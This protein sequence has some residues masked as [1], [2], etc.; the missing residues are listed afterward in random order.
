MV[1]QAISGL[2]N[3]TS[4][5]LSR[6][7]SVQRV[8]NSPITVSGTPK[9]VPGYSNVYFFEVFGANATNATLMPVHQGSL[10]SVEKDMN[11]DMLVDFEMVGKPQGEAASAIQCPMDSGVPT[12]MTVTPTSGCRIYFAIYNFGNL[13]A[14]DKLYIDLSVKDSSGKMGLHQQVLGQP[15]GNYVTTIF[16]NP[17]SVSFLYRTDTTLN[18]LIELTQSPNILGA[19]YRDYTAQS[20]LFLRSWA[21]LENGS[22][23]N[24]LTF[25]L[26]LGA[27]GNPKLGVQKLQTI[28]QSSSSIKELEILFELMDAA[29]SK[30]YYK[31]RA[32][33]KPYSQ[34]SL[35]V[36]LNWG[37][38][39]SSSPY[40]SAPS[41]QTLSGPLNSTFYVQ[42]TVLKNQ[43]NQIF[44][45]CTSTGPSGFTYGSPLY[46]LST[47]A[48]LSQTFHCQDI[49]VAT[50]GTA[51]SLYTITGTWSVLATAPP[52]VGAV[53]GGL[54]TVALYHFN[55]G[56][57]Y[58]DSSSNTNTALSSTMAGGA[59]TS[60]STG[61]AGMFSTAGVSFTNTSGYFNVASAS[62]TYSNPPSSAMTVE[63]FMNLSALPGTGNYITLVSKSASGVSGSYGWEL[64]LENVS[65]SYVLKFQGIQSGGVAYTTW[66]ASIS[67]SVNSWYY[68]GAIF[69]GSNVNFRFGAPGATLNSV[70]GSRTGNSISSLLWTS[71]PIRI[72]ANN[73]VGSGKSERLQGALDEIRISNTARTINSIPTSEF[74]AD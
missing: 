5:V 23:V 29:G 10:F 9:L 27:G 30:L 36:F 60:P 65:G 67:P 13:N 46:F 57:D 66:T 3:G 53:G 12:Q 62:A 17:A 59:S 25:Q 7:F 32:K 31:A 18:P 15:A 40:I 37:A 52:V 74:T 45:E 34:A 2:T 71:D 6:S 39:P 73:V 58:T 42:D 72:G 47:A 70:S 14:T 54:A 11:A 4:N 20:P 44:S 8:P 1:T 63:G 55:S 61:S 16:N 56:S 43:Q 68:F 64:N 49:S 19:G 28:G 21:R 24:G 33:F 35:G 69:D 41:G 38:T 48:T 22:M 50:L 51:V 26:G